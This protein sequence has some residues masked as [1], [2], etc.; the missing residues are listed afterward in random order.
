MLLASQI[1]NTTCQ[2]YTFLGHGLSTLQGASEKDVAE[3][4]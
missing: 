1:I 2:S 4:D 3:V